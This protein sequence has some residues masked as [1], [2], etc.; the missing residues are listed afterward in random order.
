MNWAHTAVCTEKE[1]FIKRERIS[2][3][4]L[5]TRLDSERVSFERI[6]NSAGDHKQRKKRSSSPNSVHSSIFKR[7]LSF[8]SSSSSGVKSQ[9]PI[10]PSTSSTSSVHFSR[11]TNRTA[12]ITSIQHTAQLNQ[13][14]STGARSSRYVLK[15]LIWCTGPDAV[16]VL[17]THK[18]PR[19]L[20]RF[21]SQIDFSTSAFSSEFC[22]SEAKSVHFGVNTPFASPNRSEHFGHSNRQATVWLSQKFR[23]FPKFRVFV[24]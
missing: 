8:N 24:L 4:V 21:S 6:T 13:L 11:S 22:R 14:E 23:V 20:A 15:I 7:K 19:D 18:C 10:Q 9:P 16:K 17:R 12:S 2:K 5:S 1:K 3:V